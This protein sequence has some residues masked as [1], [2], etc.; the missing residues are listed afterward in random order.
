MVEGWSL[1]RDWIGS[2]V[3]LKGLGISTKQQTCIKPSR[4]HVEIPQIL[5]DLDY[6]HEHC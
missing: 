6:D 1:T 3:F 5:P 4:S 2:P